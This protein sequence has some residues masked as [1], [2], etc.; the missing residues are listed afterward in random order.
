MCALC[1]FCADVHPVVNIK[2]VFP[3]TEDQKYL[4]LILYTV[5]SLFQILSFQQKIRKK[6]MAWIK[7]YGDESQDLYLY[8][9]I[10]RQHRNCS[11]ITLL[12]FNLNQGLCAT[13]EATSFTAHLSLALMNTHKQ[14][15]GHFKG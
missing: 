1:A 3:W 7:K 2:M 5:I 12:T 15:K 6:I 9:Y 11:F 10:R 4:L 14:K 8:R 13:P